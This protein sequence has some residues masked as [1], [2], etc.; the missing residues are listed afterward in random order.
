MFDICVIGSVT[1]D[2]IRISG[3]PAKQMPGGTAYYTTSALAAL[4]VKVA[5]VTHV[6]AE[7]RGFLLKGLGEGG[8]VVFDSPGGTAVFENT[9][10]PQNPDMRTQ[11][12]L[13]PATCFSSADLGDVSAEIF[14][15]GPLIQDEMS[16]SF[17]RQVKGR[18]GLVSLDAQGLIRRVSGDV[19]VPANWLE[20]TEGLSHVD[21]LK[22]D[23][24]EAM[25]LSGEK[26]LTRAGEALSRLGPREIIITCGSRGSLIFSAGERFGIA[27]VP[28]RCI[29]DPTGCGDTY[30]AGYLYKHLAGHSPEACAR[31]GA[32]LATIK[33]EGPGALS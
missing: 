2:I 22:V 18:G 15:L 16:V 32:S 28:P 21:I 6:A 27:A 20:K 9:Y 13:H 7:D 29:D 19:V 26:D 33:L 30:M 11:R 10:E 3:R 8:A 5:V 1:R 31:F 17:I 24:A 23:A 12:V 4:G 25:G 14:H